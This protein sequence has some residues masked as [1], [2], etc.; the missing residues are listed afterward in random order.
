M[1]VRMGERKK[2]RGESEMGGERKVRESETEGGGKREGKEG[3]RLSESWGRDRVRVCVCVRE[4][5]RE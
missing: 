2:E 3:A 4:G 1:R 5:G